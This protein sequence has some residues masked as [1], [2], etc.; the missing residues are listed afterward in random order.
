[1]SQNAV[2]VRPVET[3]KSRLPAMLKAMPAVMHDRF[4][5]AAIAIAM[6]PM[7]ADCTPESVVRQVFACARLNLIPD[8][9]LHLA[10][11]VPFRNGKTGKKEATL[12]I[13]YRGLVELAK[14]ADP[15]LWLKASTVYEND[16][17]E[18]VEGSVDRLTIKKRWWEKNEA[19][20]GR[21]LFF[22]CVSKQANAEEPL[23]TI[24]S[25]AEAEKIGKASKAGM[26]EGTP[27]HDN[28]ERM[29]EKTTI[30]R[31]SRFWR[32]DPDKSETRVFREAINLDEVADSPADTDTSADGLLDGLGNSDE[33]AADNIPSG[34]SR[35]GSLAKDAFKEQQK[36]EK[37]AVKPAAKPP[38][39][40]TR[41]Q[42]SEALRKMF[43]KF[44]EAKLIEARVDDIHTAQLKLL[45]KITG[46]TDPV[47][48]VSKL[49]NCT[50]AEHQAWVETL[51]K[52]SKEEVLL[53]CDEA[54]DVTPLEPEVVTPEEQSLAFTGTPTLRAVVD[55][56]AEARN[57]E[58]EEAMVAVSRYFHLK[59]STKAEK[60]PVELFALALRQI[61]ERTIKF[62]LYDLKKD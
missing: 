57:L 18:L 26:R 27:W 45:V 56:W 55:A 51:K 32:M 11:I 23:L 34:E 12:V 42:A 36:P 1:M 13:E 2:A 37:P 39:D 7:I 15:S 49:S 33:D 50:L 16:D 58:T 25:A 38:V 29:G 24:I 17:Y 31:S 14:R 60:A 62:E 6:S 41:E 4:K 48:V 59:H 44:V 46:A 30:R 61:A 52:M 22:Y 53:C 10:A 5:Q 20:P 35:I 21:P 47:E 19:G 8:P 3:L 40:P 43:A 9:V 54:P 28:F